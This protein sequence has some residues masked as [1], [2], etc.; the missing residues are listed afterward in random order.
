MN[1]LVSIVKAFFGFSKNEDRMKCVFC[2]DVV[3]HESSIGSPPEAEYHDGDPYC[4]DC[5]DWDDVKPI[6]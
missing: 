4:P 1:T 2:G 3:V 5:W 6:Q